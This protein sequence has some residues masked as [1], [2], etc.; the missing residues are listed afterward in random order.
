[1][2]MKCKTN[3]GSANIQPVYTLNLI[4]FAP[5]TSETNGWLGKMLRTQ[6]WIVRFRSNLVCWCIRCIMGLVI[7]AENDWRDVRPQVAMQR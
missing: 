4:Q 1:M 2:Y 6:L 5:L 3:S 7:K